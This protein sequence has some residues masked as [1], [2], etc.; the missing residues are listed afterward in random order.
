V[1][2]GIHMTAGVQA[3]MDAAYD[4]TGTAL[5]IMFLQ[6]LYLKL[7]I[8]L[9]TWWRAHLEFRVVEFE[10]D[11]DQLADREGHS[12]LRMQFKNQVLAWRQRT[13]TSSIWVFLQS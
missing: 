4:L 10:A 12:G 11:V 2:G 5:G 8:A 3:H 7:H 1:L 6:D 9:E 13:V